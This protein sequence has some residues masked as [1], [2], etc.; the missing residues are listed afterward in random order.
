MG[1]PHRDDS[2]RV[3]AQAATARVAHV[4][5]PRRL[6]ARL[7]AAASLPSRVAPHAALLVAWLV[8]CL[9][10]LTGRH[11][12]GGD[13]LGEFYPQAVAIAR[14][15]RAG[16][17]PWFTHDSMLGMPILGDPQSLL[18][19]AHAIAAVIG[20]AGFTVRLFDLVTLA[21]PLLGACALASVAQRLGGDRRMATLGAIVFM[22]G[23]VASTRLQHTP[24]IVAYALIPVLLWAGHAVLRCSEVRPCAAAG[25][26]LLFFA[27]AANPNQVVY[28]ALPLLA[29]CAAAFV[30]ASASPA[31]VLAGNAVIAL[32]VAAALLLP[33]ADATEAVVRASTRDALPLS[34]SA[35]NSLPFHSLISW[36]MP[37]AH[38][39]QADRPW[40]VAEHQD[41]LYLGVLPIAL[42][43][44]YGAGSQSARGLRRAWIA[45]LLLAVVY[46]LGTH[47]GIYGVLRE[48]LP[49]ASYFRR[50]ADAMFPA[51]LCIAL[52][53]ATSRF[54]VR[55]VPPA[56]LHWLAIG[57]LPFT[58]LA[59]AGWSE[60]ALGRGDRELIDI[61]LRSFFLTF[62]LAGV[63][64]LGLST[65][66]ISST[67]YAG[68]LLL[69]VLDLCWYARWTPLV[70]QDVGAQPIPP[71]YLGVAATAEAQFLREHASPTARAE[72]VGGRLAG[73]YALYAGIEATLGYNPLQLRP[74]AT[75][76]GTPYTA[77]EPRE[78]AH[79]RR[80]GDPD[81][82]AL[83]LGYV[84]I[85]TDLLATARD[86]ASAAAARRYRDALAASGAS[87]RVDGLEY[88]IW[89]VV[90]AHAA[91]CTPIHWESTKVKLDCRSEAATVTHL[92]LAAWPGWKLCGGS[93]R[94]IADRTGLVAVALPAGRRTTISLK[95]W[96]FRFGDGCDAAR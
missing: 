4:L 60:A 29:V 10:W 50:P 42:A 19:G 28:L 94:L 14:L 83:A 79:G 16:E 35:A 91:P 56:R 30:R 93:A 76:F 67:R 5:R 15:V 11:V 69:A 6:R 74:Y 2:S 45:L 49:G 31:R 7:A 63:V 70:A 32:A 21:H 90:S 44:R 41:H 8:S 9:P 33:L 17:K 92:P 23:G 84:A 51:N 54:D 96:P 40:T 88:E 71:D 72:I 13:S 81:Y 73:A 53:I 47:T 58:L 24:L 26:G 43:L 95:Y 38:G 77:V 20:G 46:A 68:L 55:A 52:L 86:D 80:P 37:N 27:W 48:A 3:V 12:V 62:A 61:G 85:A 39:L 78:L 25:L 22:L 59:T 64:L 1:I 65:R 36:L 75:H 34:A 87:L 57:L 89:A 66:P 18:F 82:D